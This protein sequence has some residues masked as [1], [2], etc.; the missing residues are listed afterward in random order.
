MSSDVV[1]TTIPFCLPDEHYPVP[2]DD[3]TQAEYNQHFCWLVIKPIYCWLQMN[4]YKGTE[5]RKSNLKCPVD[6]TVIVKTSA[7]QITVSYVDKLLNNPDIQSALKKFPELYKKRHDLIWWI[8]Q[9]A[10]ISDRFVF[11]CQFSEDPIPS[12]N[13][14]LISLGQTEWPDVWYI[15][16]MTL[17][18]GSTGFK[19]P[20]KGAGNFGLL[21]VTKQAMKVLLKKHISRLVVK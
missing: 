18:Q 13:Y 17:I 8:Q 20:C 12:Q 5:R 3:W 4:G 16:R 14:P 19:N 6:K 10:P 21:N 9:L 2:N 1:K 7:H 11:I 15:K